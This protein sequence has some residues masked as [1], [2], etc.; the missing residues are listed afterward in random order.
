MIGDR[1][2]MAAK[3]NPLELH[4]TAALGDDAKSETPR[5]AA[6]SRPESRL[7]RGRSGLQLEGH[8]DRGLWSEAERGEVFP[9][10]MQSH[11]LAQIGSD[12]VKRRTLGDYGDFEALGHESRL[13]PRPNDCLDRVL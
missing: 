12:F 9:F 1:K 6:I 10:Q 8:H 5:A 4:V 2:A 7:S 3:P 11:R 13:L